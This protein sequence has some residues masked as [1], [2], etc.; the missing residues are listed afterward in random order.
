MKKLKELSKME[1]D[2]HDVVIFLDTLKKCVDVINKSQAKDFYKVLR[3]LS[4]RGTT[5]VVASHTNKRKE[6]DGKYM[7]EG[8]GDLKADFDELI[9]IEH[10]K[11]ILINTVTTY[12]D[13]VRGLF[14]PITFTINIKTRE[15]NSQSYDKLNAIYL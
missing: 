2:L 10:K 9:Y 14:K 11:G 4:A 8:T 3:R 6:D 13:K 15:I 7:F 12:P 5:I 1:A